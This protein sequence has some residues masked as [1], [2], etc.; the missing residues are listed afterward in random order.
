VAQLYI[1]ALGSL[2]VASY[3]RRA[4][5]EVFEPASKRTFFTELLDNIVK[6]KVKVML[7]PT[8]S[9]PVCLGTKH[10][11]GAYDQILIIV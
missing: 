2:F 8:V 1:Q 7:R 6:V 5:V 4:M 3:T 11:F 10:P 9:R